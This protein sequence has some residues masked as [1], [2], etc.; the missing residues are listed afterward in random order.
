MVPDTGNPNPAAA[1]ACAA[2]E[3]GDPR[4]MLATLLDHLPGM[5]YR[6]RNDR[7]WTMEFV[8]EGCRAL[9]GYTPAELVGSRVVA[10]GDL[11]L[12]EDREKIWR[13]VQ[14]ALAARAS[15]QLTYRLRRPDGSMAWLSE[16]GQGVF[17]TEG[18]AEALEGFIT[19]V[20]AQQNAEQALLASE[21]K[22]EKAFLASPDAI[23]VHEMASGRYVDVNPGMLQLFGYSR[24]ELIGCIPTELGMWVD[25][26]ERRAFLAALRRQGSVRDFKA[27]MRLKDGRIRLC[28][29]SAEA[30][31]IGG[32]AHNVTVLRDVTE[33]RQTEQTLRDSEKKFATAFQ[34]SPMA[35]TIVEMANG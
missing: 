23:S 25:E 1:A 27:S 13:Q 7:A 29:L 4:R 16:R 30:M 12:A 18:V 8:S 35:L 9:T 28:E 26:T 17:T 32:Q 11:I 21:E 34:A 14:A 2:D 33:S 15:Y 24:G 22:F 20:T 19:D 10:Y 5:A 3:L 31:T 6:C